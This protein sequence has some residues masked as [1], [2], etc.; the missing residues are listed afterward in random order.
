MIFKE[1]QH[2]SDRVIERGATDNRIVLAENR[3]RYPKVCLAH[4]VEAH[5]V[6]FLQYFTS[7][8]PMADRPE[9]RPMSIKEVENH[10]EDKPVL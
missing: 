5:M 6:R 7:A 3:R 10:I 2:I 8:T 9:R 1:L 4:T